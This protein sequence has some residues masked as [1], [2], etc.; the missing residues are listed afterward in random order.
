MVFE[1]HYLIR[2]IWMYFV[3]SYIHTNTFT[4]TPTI[5]DLKHA[6]LFSSRVVLWVL[7]DPGE[8]F[9]TLAGLSPLV[10]IRAISCV[11]CLM[12]S[13]TTYLLPAIASL[14]R[15]TRC[16]GA[17]VIDRAMESGRDRLP[18]VRAE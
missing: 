1:K 15:T 2:Y 14:L 17:L 18:L 16:L 11:S 13:S 9:L 4:S 10:S 5:K 6:I 8:I 7:G 12:F 3:C